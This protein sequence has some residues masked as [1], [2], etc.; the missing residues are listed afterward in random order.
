M[1]TERHHNCPASLDPNPK[2]RTLN[3]VVLEDDYRNLLKL[4]KA[5]LGRSTA[6]DLGN[7]KFMASA[8]KMQDEY[9][10]DKNAKAYAEGMQGVADA[11]KLYAKYKNPYANTQWA[12][13]DNKEDTYKAK[14]QALALKPVSSKVTQLN[15]AAARTAKKARASCHGEPA[16]EKV[17]DQV[18]LL[19][20]CSS[21]FVSKRHRFAPGGSNSLGEMTFR[22]ILEAK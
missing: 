20:P 16:C 12:K 6:L 4:S 15:H 21:F 5:T 10:K 3:Q 14:T 13:Y 19:K 18:P 11:G 17:Y 1:E 8:G 2:L 22:R 9:V 7:E